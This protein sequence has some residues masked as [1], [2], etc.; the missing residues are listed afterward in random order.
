MFLFWSVIVI[1]LSSIVLRIDND[2]IQEI[3][4]IAF[5]IGTLVFIIDL[6]IELC[7]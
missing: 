3:G 7:K 2:K 5:V 4:L 1:L 6:V